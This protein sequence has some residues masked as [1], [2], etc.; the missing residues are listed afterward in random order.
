M[1]VE[2]YL[3]KYQPVIYK[4]FLNALENNK[5]SHA[6]LLIGNPGMPLLEISK[7]LAKSIVCEDPSPLACNNCI[8]CMRID[9]D[10]YPD[11]IVCD[12]SKESIKKSQI[13]EIEEHFGNVAFEKNGKKIYILHLIENMTIEATNSILKFLEEPEDNVYAFLTTN[14]ENSILP[15]IISR[16]QSLHLKLIERNIVIN[17]AIDLGIDQNDATILSYFYNDSELIFDLLNNEDS[18]ERFY[19]SVKLVED[20]FDTLVNQGKREAIYYTQ[21]VI[22]KNVTTKESFRFFLD[23]LAQF[24]EDLINIQNNKEVILNNYDKILHD[25]LNVITHIDESLVEILK[26]RNLINLNLNIPLQIDHLIF[27]IIKE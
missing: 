24:F 19:C 2:N 3:K 23:L 5:L 17:D 13:D 6:Y 9:D 11:F 8:T 21:T 27:E 25:S 14:N 26:Q 22:E 15:T 16:C 1:R 4:S 18:K 20:L 7:F 10:N 12:G